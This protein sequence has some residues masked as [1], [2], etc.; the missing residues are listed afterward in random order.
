MHGKRIWK[1]RI[2]K[3][4]ISKKD[5]CSR[6]ELWNSGKHKTI[7]VHRLVAN[8]F[9]ENNL[10]TNLTVNHKDGNRQN[11][12]ITNLEWLTRAENITY[13]FENGQYSNTC[14]KCTLIKDNKEYE[15][16]SQAKASK[17]LNK[18][19]SYINNKIKRKQYIAIDNKGE[20]YLIKT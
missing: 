9:L 1:D 7:L 12:N 3:Q 13:G 20:K 16:I 8:A 15:F 2:L 14:K 10:N 19:H 5:R 17:F 18:N 4:K 11:N 6:V